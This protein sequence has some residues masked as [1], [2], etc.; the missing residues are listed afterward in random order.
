MMLL[1]GGA[2]ALLSACEPAPPPF[3]SIDITGAPY[4]TGFSL[5]DANGVTRTLADFKGKVVLL[6]F[7]FTQCP[8][9]CPTALSR[10]V[11]VRKLLGADGA[12]V[13]VVMLSVD[14]ERDTPE[15]LRE[16][17]K[18]FDPEFV[19]LRGDAQSTAATAKEFKVFYQKVATSGSYTM[20][21]TAV[22]YAFDPRGRLRLAIRHPQSAEEVA[23]D[24]KVLLRP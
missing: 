15:V 24:L 7:G 2:S 12:K 19:A 17:V 5:P 8:D 23:A 21:H 10:A 9:V 14:P 6:F 18:A 13:A 3:K 22:T 11:E 20:D 4:G 1:G 16:Y